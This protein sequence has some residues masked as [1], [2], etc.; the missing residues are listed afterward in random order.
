VRPRY[1]VGDLIQVAMPIQMQLF[2]EFEDFGANS[3]GV[4]KEVVKRKSEFETFEYS[5]IVYIE[6]SDLMFFEYE[7]VPLKQK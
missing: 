4:I 1:S 2:S 7:L 5:Y 6:G 3:I